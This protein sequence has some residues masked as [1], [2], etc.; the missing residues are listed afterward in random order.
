V[1]DMAVK[2][3]FTLARME[4]DGRSAQTPRTRTLGERRRQVVARRPVWHVSSEGI[5]VFSD[6][7][8]TREAYIMAWTNFL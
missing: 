5:F 1:H 3:C 6:E 7:L 8:C 4:G 2:L